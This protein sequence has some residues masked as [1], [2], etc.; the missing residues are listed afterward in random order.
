MTIEE[1]KKIITEWLSD[2]ECGVTFKKCDAYEP[3]KD[4]FSI[5]SNEHKEAMEALCRNGLKV[6]FRMKGN[7]KMGEFT[8]GE[9][10]V[11]NDNR[12]LKGSCCQKEGD[13]A[14][15]EQIQEA[16]DAVRKFYPNVEFISDDD[17]YPAALYYA[18]FD[19]SVTDYVNKLANFGI[20]VR[21]NG[22]TLES[23]KE[24]LSETASQ[25]NDAI[26]DEQARM[27][28]EKDS[29]LENCERQYGK[30]EG[31]NMVLK[32]KL[33]DLERV[34]KGKAAK[35]RELGK[36][37][38]RL[39]GAL[40]EK[41]EL[42]KNLISD[43]GKVS[44][45]LHAEKAIHEIDLQ[46]T[47]SAESALIYKESEYEKSLREKDEVIDDLSREL[48]H[49][50]KR[51]EELMATVKDYL[52]EIDGL[53]KEKGAEGKTIKPADVT[54]KCAA[55]KDGMG[56][57]FDDGA[58]RKGANEKFAGR[59]V[60]VGMVSERKKRKKNA[61]RDSAKGAKA[62]VE[63]GKNENRYICKCNKHYEEVC[64][65]GNFVG[66]SLRKKNLD[67]RF[68]ELMDSCLNGFAGNGI[69]FTGGC[70]SRKDDVDEM[71]EDMEGMAEEIFE[72][73]KRHL[74]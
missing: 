74:W 39:N 33:E 16:K 26:L 17:F 30:L 59:M 49:S 1:A 53:R 20:Y 63:K 64:N 45:E 3:S 57:D 60:L 15:D 55:D 4:V 73:I 52:V 69:G 14:L 51:E 13:G 23:S 32:A 27:I 7:D 65:G 42:V 47:K 56:K 9:N 35:V 19:K 43:H 50:K 11:V 10:C 48:A 6:R 62:R 21:M 34:R 36:E 67:A 61:G 41:N 66:A 40:H 28:R 70:K 38:A 68:D 37:I 22:A 25:F 5:Y 24:H 71:S 54:Q 46:A 12:N 2:E 58:W 29:L 18:Q 72:Q 8:F 44:R 31:Q